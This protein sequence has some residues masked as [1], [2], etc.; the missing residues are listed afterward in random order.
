M[1]KAGVPGRGGVV[2][3]V[4]RD[5]VGTVTVHDDFVSALLGGQRT[6]RV[7]LPPGYQAQPWRRYP[8]FYMHDGQNLFDG[9]VSFIPGVTWRVAESADDLIRLS[10]IE[11]LIVVGIDN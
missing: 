1:G 7:Y 2:A 4:E 9:S 6:V 11:P 8:V 10:A 5:E 3:S